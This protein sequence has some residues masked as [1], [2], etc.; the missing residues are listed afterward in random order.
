MSNP[1][2]AC[3]AEQ[4]RWQ[5]GPNLSLV[6]AST[7]RHLWFLDTAVLLCVVHGMKAQLLYAMQSPRSTLRMQ[8]INATV[9]GC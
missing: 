6:L 9:K 3:F 5:V 2:S 4:G 1:I 8:R 7:E